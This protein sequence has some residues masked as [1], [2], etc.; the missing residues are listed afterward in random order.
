M[1]TPPPP[2]TR[3]LRSP[4]APPC[5]QYLQPEETYPPSTLS[6]RAR[7]W[8][9]QRI[10]RRADLARGHKANKGCPYRFQNSHRCTEACNTNATHTTQ[11][12]PSCTHTR[13]ELD[14]IMAAVAQADAGGADSNPS[15]TGLGA[16][17]AVADGLDL[18][19]LAAISA[20][21]TPRSGGASNSASPTACRPPVH[22]QIVLRLADGLTQIKLKA[23]IGQASLTEVCFPSTLKEI[24]SHAFKDC[25]GLA[26]LRLPDGLRK[27]GFGAFHGAGVS[28]LHLP[29]SVEKIGSEAFRDCTRLSEVDLPRGLS[30]IGEGML[31][32]GGRVVTRGAFDGCT[33]LAHVGAPV[34]LVSGG[35]ASL[36]TV[37]K[38]CPVLVS[39][40]TPLALPLAST[41]APASDP[42]GPDRAPA[43]AH[44]HARATGSHGVQAAHREELG[45]RDCDLETHGAASSTTPTATPLWPQ[46]ANT[47][48]LAQ[49]RTDKPAPAILAASPRILA[50]TPA[51]PA[52]PTS[53][54]ASAPEQ[55]RASVPGP[56]PV[57]PAQRSTPAPA[58]TVRAPSFDLEAKRK[59]QSFRLGSGAKKARS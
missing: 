9:Q 40:L 35:M 44:P 51:P 20:A 59:T 27:I 23:Y 34:A 53:P 37:F 49:T 39:G 22:E 25:T 48:A 41:P 11:K 14:A 12:I 31:N 43:A 38:G 4:L 57:A 54:R 19:A 52:P 28:A 13:D 29:D 15:A 18:Q 33:S 32:H 8:Q 58:A 46:P 2:P 21:P 30:S 55:D 5:A 3:I 17:M 26:S 16:L 56:A 47:Q 10:L 7:S 24:K 1:C 36:A 42:H 45:T 50:I 6:T